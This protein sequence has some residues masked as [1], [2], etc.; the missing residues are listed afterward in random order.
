[1]CMKFLKLPKTLYRHTELLCGL[2]VAACGA[3]LM[4]IAMSPSLAA[5]PPESGVTQ[6]VYAEFAMMACVIAGGALLHSRGHGNVPRA[7]LWLTTGLWFAG[8]FIFFS[9]SPIFSIVGMVALLSCV[10]SVG[11]TAEDD[12][13]YVPVVQDASL[14][15][16][17]SLY[18]GPAARGTQR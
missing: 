7:A 1:M 8:S 11:W 13:S 2:V 9:L 18:G 10:S 17:L 16:R 5:I 4:A 12:D 3:I 6:I 15:G 14:L